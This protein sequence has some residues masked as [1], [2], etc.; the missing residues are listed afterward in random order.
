MVGWPVGDGDG[1]AV[2]GAG[3]GAAV[4]GDTDS[5][6][7]DN[8]DGSGVGTSVGMC[9]GTGVLGAPVSV[10]A[11]VV[12]AGVGD[13]ASVVGVSVGGWAHVTGHCRMVRSCVQSRLP[14]LLI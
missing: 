9:D 7:V 4:I 8:A 10:G 13:G 5:K 1:S 6:A 14:V 3:V 2:V 12:G 11:T